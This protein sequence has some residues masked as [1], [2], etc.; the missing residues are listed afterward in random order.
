MNIS[1]FIPNNSVLA[2]MTAA[3][4]IN[5]TDS[6]TAAS[7]SGINFGSILKDK[8]A[9]VNEKQVNANDLTT[10]FIQ[11]GD[12]SVDQVMLGSEE[13]KMSLQMAV[14]VRNKIV[15]AYQELNKIQI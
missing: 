9:Q 14:Q 2:S 15:E 5:N 12:V 7:D 10:Q 8:L 4:S 13:A 6:D 3:D 11:G 1:E